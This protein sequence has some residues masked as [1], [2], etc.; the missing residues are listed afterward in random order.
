MNLTVVEKSGYKSKGLA[1]P[2]RKSGRPIGKQDRA[3][4]PC[5]RHA[6]AL[7]QALGLDMKTW[8]TPTK[9]G[10]LKRVPKKLVLEAVTEG[11]SKQAADNLAT[12]KKDALAA[13][14]E[15]RLSGTGWLPY[16][17]RAAA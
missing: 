17:L 11:V 7:A 9:D 15:K 13:A 1:I 5:L 3:D 2:H 4:A 16:C 6:D 12:L 10:F 14:A 8:W